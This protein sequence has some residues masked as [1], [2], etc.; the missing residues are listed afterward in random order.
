MGRLGDEATPLGAE[1]SRLS[2]S[3]A[4]RRLGDELRAARESA[5]LTLGQGAAAIQRSAATLS[6]LENGQSIPRLVDISALLDHYSQRAPHALPDGARNR[7][8]DLA[9]IGRTEAWFHSFRDVISSDM[10]IDNI[11]RYIE[12][13]SDAAKICSFE[14]ELIP[15]ILQT[16]EYAASITQLFFPLHT[17]AQRERLVA[18]RLARQHVLRRPDEPLA[19]DVVIGEAAFRRVFGSPAVMRDQVHALLRISGEVPNVRVRIAPIA[20]SIPAVVGGP[21]VV[22]EFPDADYLPGVVYLES[23]TSGQYVQNT[24]VLGIY[25]Q[26]FDELKEAALDTSQSRDMLHQVLATLA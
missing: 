12:L 21:F 9:D 13:E 1:S 14:P 23:R 15:G 6:R 4:R 8:L 18:F 22:M 2:P 7:I 19:F 16:R 10:T 11:Q 17:Q 25:Q 26:L 3:S 20:L 24:R 5:R